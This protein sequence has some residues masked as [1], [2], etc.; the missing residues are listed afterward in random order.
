ML[1][2]A[3]RAQAGLLR[4][5]DVS[6]YRELG[7]LCVCVC[8]ARPTSLL[9]TPLHRPLPW[10]LSWAI[11]ECVHSSVGPDRGLGEGSTLSAQSAYPET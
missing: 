5:R 7:R 3:W 11:L 8:V 6:P 10:T 1:P 2:G 4:L 9:H